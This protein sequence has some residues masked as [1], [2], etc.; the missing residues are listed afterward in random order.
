LGCF[1]D[2]KLITRRPL[3]GLH[4]GIPMA[5]I[6]QTFAQPG[7]R[8]DQQAG[9]SHGASPSAANDAESRRQH[10]PPLRVPR[11]DLVTASYRRHELRE[12]KNA[13]RLM[14]LADPP[15]K[16]YWCP[17]F[18]MHTA[19][20]LYEN[21]INNNCIAGD[22][23]NKLPPCAASNDLTSSAPV[24]PDHRRRL[25]SAV[26]FLLLRTCKRYPSSVTRKT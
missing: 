15:N 25:A 3:L 4:S 1:V 9:F 13:P 26:T 16:I 17:D 24:P 7:H 18:A 14:S 19:L 5:T 12:G 21:A 20:E 10:I 2:R 23:S 6:P 22:H 8:Q 11:L